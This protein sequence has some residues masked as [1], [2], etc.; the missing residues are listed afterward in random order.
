MLHKI[1]FMENTI[2]KNKEK[3]SFEG[4]R[5][6][7]IASRPKD[8]PGWGHDA[9]PRNNPTYPIKDWNGADYQR[10]NYEK[11]PQQHSDIEM[12]KSIERPTLSRVYGTSTPPSGLSGMIRRFAF[13]YSESTYMHWVPLVLADRINVFEGMIEDVS[14]GIIPNIFAE[15]G[16]QAE[17]K[18]NRKATEKKIIVGAIVAVGIVALLVAKNKQKKLA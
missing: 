18:H 9:D 5:D 16:W 11:P 12:L 3:P 15:R 1:Y 13:K 4:D 14:K 17:W 6:R 8:I 7:E 2:K 10:L